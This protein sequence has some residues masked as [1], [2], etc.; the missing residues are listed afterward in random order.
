[1]VASPPLSP[2]PAGDR[3]RRRQRLDAADVAADAPHVG[4]AAHPDVADV[5]RRTVRAVM[6][7]AGTGD[8]AAPDPGA[9]LDEQQRRLVRGQRPGLAERAQV[10]VVLQ[11]RRAA[12]RAAQARGDRV[13]VP[14]RH[15]RRPDRD[16]VP[17][18]DR[19][20]HADHH[21]PRGG[22]AG[23]LRPQRAQVRLDGG[24]H[25]VRP[26]GDV[27]VD[28]P[29][30]PDGLAQVD[31]GE[32]RAVCTEVGDQHVAAARGERE[33]V[34]RAAAA[35]RGSRADHPEARRGGAARRPRCSR[36]CGRGSRRR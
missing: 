5:A 31:D 35:R 16:A 18:V 3:A 13:G 4:S 6:Q 14:A 9:D 28:V 10:H 32:V 33:P 21:R 20:R 17:A 7:L 2:E 15:D 27:D 19:T 26:L 25:R 34:R 1:M 36:S 22:V 30:G 23:H 8:Q 12:E 24:E 11:Q 29:V